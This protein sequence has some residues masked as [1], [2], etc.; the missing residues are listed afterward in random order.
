VRRLWLVA[1]CLALFV[2]GVVPAQAD[3]LEA[4]LAGVESEL[5]SVRDAL[6]SSEAQGSDLAAAILETDRRVAQV[7]R[8]L[9]EA[10]GELAAI[11]D[12]VAVTRIELGRTRSELEAQYAALEATRVELI[13]SKQRAQH[14]AIDLYMG[15]GHGVDGIVFAVDAAS[16][17]SVG[18]EY[19]TQVIDTTNQIVNGLVVLERSADRQAGQIAEREQGLEDDLAALDGQQARLAALRD[20]V[21]AQKAEVERELATQRDQLARLEEEIAHFEDELA[22]LEREQSRVAELIRQQQE[23][24]AAA[25]AAAAAEQNDDDDDGSGDDGSEPAPSSGGWVRPVPGSVTSPFG[26]RIHPIYGT[27]RLHAGVDFRAGHGEPIKA[28]ADGRVILASSYGGYGNTVIVDHGGG[29]ATLYAHQ[30]RVA[31]SYGD[32]VAAGEVIGYVGSTGLSTGAH[33]HW[34]VR[35]GG[36]PVDPMQ[37]V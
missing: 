9:A 34:E 5:V 16:E 25:A 6:R 29:V 2:A 30:S 10:E 31:V 7:V 36:A 37:Y 32:R 24:A 17:L 13:E 12:S 19:A 15:G 23:A 4:D 14:R 22:K 21:A 1:S 18:M 26:Y 27:K 28:A 8:N 35:R 33:L 20:E 3:E 11:T